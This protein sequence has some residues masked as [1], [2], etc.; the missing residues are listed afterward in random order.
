MLVQCARL[1][2]ESVLLTDVL[3]PPGDLRPTLSPFNSHLI[4]NLSLVNIIGNIIIAKCSDFILN[5][6]LGHSTGDIYSQLHQVSNCLCIPVL[7]PEA[8]KNTI[9]DG[10]STPPLNCRYHPEENT[11]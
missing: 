8:T 1:A 6:P 11:I 4:P 5:S 3:A 2:P 9:T 10:G 7:Q